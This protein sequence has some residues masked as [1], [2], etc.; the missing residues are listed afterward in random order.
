MDELTTVAIDWDEWQ[1]LLSCPLCRGRLFCN[2][3]FLCCVATAEHTFPISPEGVPFFALE[4]CSEAGVIQRKHYNR[5]SERY[6]AN[7]GFPHTQE[8]TAALDRTLLDLLPG[9]DLGTVVELC[10]GQGEGLMLLEDRTTVGM[11]L[12]VSE[13]MILTARS[14]LS[15]GHHLL[16]QADA[17]MPPLADE[18]AD[19]VV[20][21][22]GIHHISDRF[23]LFSEVHR[24]LKSG[25]L[26]LFREPLNDA[27]LWRAL[28]AL[29]Y[30][31]SPALDA[32]T[33]RPLRRSE[34]V[35]TLESCGFAIE[36][37]SPQGLLGFCLLMNS[38]VLVLNGLLRFVPGIRAISRTLVEL[39]RRCLRLPG[40]TN[41][42]LQVVGAARKGGAE[43]TGIGRGARLRASEVGCDDELEALAEST[44]EDFGREWLRYPDNEG[45]FASTELLADIL[46]PLL[47]LDELEGKS[48]AEI[49]SGNGRIVNMLLDTGA[50]EVT[51]LEPSE[52]FEVLKRNTADRARSIQYIRGRGEELPPEPPVDLVVSIGVLH[53]IPEPVPVM[54][55]AHR[56]LKPGGRMVAW[57]YGRENNQAYLSWV[58]P[59]RR[60]TSKLP[61]GQVIV[62][63]HLFNIALDGYLL[64]CRSGKLGLPLAKYMN[65]YMARLTRHKRHLVIYDQLSPG[66]AH[67]YSRREAKALFEAGGFEDIR[68]H[69]RHGYSWTVIGTKADP[70]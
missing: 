67:Y 57:L 43:S 11:G 2:E 58:L 3:A 56:A 33:E 4:H 69:H 63:S 40:L 16:V 25:G 70:R 62:L 10:C 17:T 15:P 64:L 46:G 51:A 65:A 44:I 31:L 23:R 12:D 52:A 18:S 47:S 66:Y 36:R 7:I 20:I 8:Y 53:H 9:G 14:A 60:F 29:V 24:V 61:D 1:D 5:V 37:W 6:L 39:D 19:V 34:T 49:G 22:G 21:L 38:D 27:A 30:R 35:A 48:I 42:G 54:R 28:R 13:A 32:E 59:L 50:S 45:Y 55:A 26:L 68:L 41:A